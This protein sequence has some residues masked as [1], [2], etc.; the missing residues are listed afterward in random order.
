MTQLPTCCHREVHGERIVCHSPK[1]AKPPNVVDADT[2]QNRCPR[3]YVNAA[4]DG[5]A[6]VPPR[7]V[8]RPAGGPGTELA[9]FLSRFGIRP[10][11][12]GCRCE[13]RAAEMDARGPDWCEVNL[14]TIVGWLREEAQR[15]GGLTWKLF[16]ETVARLLVRRAVKIARRKRQNES[17]V[18]S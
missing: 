14:D 10:D 11:E 8:R 15:R 12:A 4:C 5:Q 18:N 17:S 1:F 13:A 9:R 16:S 7:A 2:C 6:S 3:H